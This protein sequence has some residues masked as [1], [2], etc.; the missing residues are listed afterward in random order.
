MIRL[1]MPRARALPALLVALALAACGSQRTVVVRDQ[2]IRLRSSEYRLLPE[3]VQARAGLIRIES[4]NDGRLTHNVKVFSTV[5][6]DP[7]G[8]FVMLGGTDTAH[9]AE[10]ARGVVDLKPGRYRLACSLGNH[11]D[12]GEYAILVVTP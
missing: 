10:T 5:L 7:Q 8:N 1:S 6:K 3:R 12:L 2:T 11:E 4:L 9:H